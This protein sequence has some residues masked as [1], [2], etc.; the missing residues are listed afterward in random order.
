MA[1]ARSSCGGF[2]DQSFAFQASIK[3]IHGKRKFKRMLSFFF[4]DKR[5]LFVMKLSFKE[6]NLVFFTTERLACFQQT[7]AARSVQ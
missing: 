2:Q 7:K 6:F 5:K 1:G 4:V 3:D